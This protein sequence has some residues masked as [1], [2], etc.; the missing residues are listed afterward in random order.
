MIVGK[1]GE[2]VPIK[3]VSSWIKK[4]HKLIAGHKKYGPGQ[5]VLPEMGLVQKGKRTFNIHVKLKIGVFNPTHS[6]ATHFVADVV[7]PPICVR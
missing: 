2:D 4:L 5:L 7:I 1:R 6:H 3:M